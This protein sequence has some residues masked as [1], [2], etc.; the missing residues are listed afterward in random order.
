MVSVVKMTKFVLV[1]NAIKM[2]GLLN[3]VNVIIITGLVI[4]V[5][6]VILVRISYEFSERSFSLGNGSFA[7]V[8][9]PRFFGLQ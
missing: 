1:S 4:A 8:V 6:V 5:N 3:M 9:K 2:T 7:F